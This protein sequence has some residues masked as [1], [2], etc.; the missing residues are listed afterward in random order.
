MEYENIENDF[1]ERTLKL[2][3]E[4]TG[5]FEVTL[6]INCCLGLLVLP[7]EKHL[8]SIP[9]EEIP[10]ERSLWGISRERL[11]VDCGSCGY[12]LKDVIRRIRNGI[13]HF[14]IKTIPDGSEE[15]STLEIRDRGNF[16]VEFN[17]SQMRELAESLGQHVISHNE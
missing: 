7:K 11:S 13:C 8:N 5:E 9:D 16:K 12:S 3:R 15:I 10:L 17:V 4:Y 2:I 1:V 14:K 6:L